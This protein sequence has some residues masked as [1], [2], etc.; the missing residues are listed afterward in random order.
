MPLQALL[1]RILDFVWTWISPQRLVDFVFGYDYFISY[2]QDDG[3][4]Y[5]RSLADALGKQGY[6]VFIDERGYSA[7]DDLLLSTRRR[8]RMSS[9]LLLIARPGALT[10][11]D[12]VVREVEQCLQAQRV[13]IVVDI[14]DCFL[15]V[16][17]SSVDE[18]HRLSMLRQLLMGRLR[19]IEA[20]GDAADGVFD[21]KPSE[22]TLRELKRSFTARRQ[23][24]RRARAFGAAA[25]LFGMLSLAATGLAVAAMLAQQ[26]ADREARRARAGELAAQSRLSRERQP[27]LSDLLANEA[28]NVVLS[29][30]EP[31]PATARQALVE[32][33]VGTT[34]EGIPGNGAELGAFD[35]SP[36]GHWWVFGGDDGSIR[37]WEMKADGALIPA[38][39]VRHAGTLNVRFAAFSASSQWLVTAGDGG[40]GCLWSMASPRNLQCL[41]MA[42]V[43]TFYDV[44]ISPDRRWVAAAGHDNSALLW[45]LTKPDPQNGTEI[46]ND[47]TNARFVRFSD[48]ARELIVWGMINHDSWFWDLRQSPPRAPEVLHHPADVSEAVVQAENGNVADI[49]EAGRIA[50]WRKDANWSSFELKAASKDSVVVN[51]L[52]MSESGVWLAAAIAPGRPQDDAASTLYVWQLSSQGEPL[53]SK[54]F[55]LEG[56]VRGLDFSPNDQMLYVEGLK[57]LWILN[58]MNGLIAAA[59]ISLPGHFDSVTQHAFSPDARFLATGD[60]EGGVM[61]WDFACK[62]MPPAPIALRGHESAVRAL[63]F[64]PGASWLVSASGDGTG[65]RWNMARTL[66]GDALTLARACQSD[67]SVTTI[68]DDRAWLANGSTNGNVQLYD[69]SAEEPSI[70]LHQM[71]N[72]DHS[73]I[74]HLWFDPTNRW[75][76]AANKS[77]TLDVWDLKAQSIENSRRHLTRLNRSVDSVGFLPD[78]RRIVTRAA[79]GTAQVVDLMQDAPDASAVILSIP[80]A[81]IDD[82]FLSKDGRWLAANAYNHM[83]IW[84]LSHPL[85][86]P[87]IALPPFDAFI[88][89]VH[90]AEDSSGLV[91]IDNSGNLRAWSLPIGNPQNYLGFSVADRSCDVI[92]SRDDQWMAVTTTVE[93]HLKVF[94]LADRARPPLPVVPKQ[95]A[96]GNG[97]IAFSEDGVWL[98][99]SSD[100]SVQLWKTAELKQPPS[101]LGASSLIE[102]LVF[103]EDDHWLAYASDRGD[104]SVAEM[105]PEGPQDPIYTQAH[106]G[107]VSFLDFDTTNRSLISGSYY[108]LILTPLDIPRLL[109]LAEERAGRNFKASEWNTY[110]RSQPYRKTFSRLPSLDSEV[111]H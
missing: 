13:P 61:L 16:H 31:V 42:P 14:N 27:Q 41:A 10:R 44:S 30:G 60:N 54:T 38:A 40:E 26:Q 106:R 47:L 69:L 35:I 56:Q 43:D 75:L 17:A 100:K 39:T 93:P 46:G 88:E 64:S 81:E 110:F 80:G 71:P 28:V 49:D 95:A 77:E 18:A 94:Q 8:V 45:D 105:A 6:K 57:G 24:S 25:V 78:G 48:D 58:L 107:A 74:E 50:L 63:R 12:W 82:V 4:H 99:Y 34:G 76:V 70:S 83:Y 11:S 79:G 109:K 72:N 98:A 87:P 101:V 89:T 92:F 32:A 2:K 68:S 20:S 33:V 59:P 73:S 22:H 67:L 5:P 84:D 9:Y 91:A 29:A 86:A 37:L 90:F 51:G 3:H 19:I 97:I 15:T 66:P 1:L 36:D 53:R 111:T 102:R 23:D 21:G 52:A 85:S 65:R 55:L 7:G 62:P 104:V 96:E 108:Q 103:S